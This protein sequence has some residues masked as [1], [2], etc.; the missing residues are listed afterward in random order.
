MTH[1][2]AHVNKSCNSRGRSCACP[3]AITPNS[4]HKFLNPDL[5]GGCPYKNQPN[6]EVGPP[7]SAL[8]FDMN[9]Y[10]Y[11]MEIL[12]SYFKI[13]IFR[14]AEKSPARNW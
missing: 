1:T 2:Y 8:S 14:I 13:T 4:N 6:V 7:R 3:K 10:C 11:A 5:S 12:V 9:L